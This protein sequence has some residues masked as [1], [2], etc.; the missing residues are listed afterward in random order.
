MWILRRLKQSGCPNKEL[1]IVMKNQVVSV[2]E[3]GVPYW[4]PM[5]TKSESNQIEACLKTALN[6]IFQDE[7]I[8]NCHYF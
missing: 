2:C 5:I 7:Y 8:R 6:I 3:V 1:V 4:A